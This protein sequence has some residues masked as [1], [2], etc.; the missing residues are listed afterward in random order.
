MGGIGTLWCMAESERTPYGERLLK[1]RTHAKLSQP[2]L[3]KAVG[4]R[5]STIGELEK[6][7]SGSQKTTQMALACG[8]RPEW[9]ASGDGPMLPPPTAKAIPE[10][11][12]IAEALS[13][14]DKDQFDFAMQ[15]IRYAL[16]AAPLKKPADQQEPGENDKSSS[17][18]RA[19]M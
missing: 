1:A 4:L 9:L 5:Q 10:L 11:E 17:S 19:A 13:K 8:V 12:E 16:E 15:G 18:F 6:K 3:A 2:Q 7:G 14:L